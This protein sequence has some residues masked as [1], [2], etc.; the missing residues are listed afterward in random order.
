MPSGLQP[1]FPQSSSARLLMDR[2]AGLSSALH[3]L[4]SSSASYRSALEGLSTANDKGIET[5]PATSTASD[6]TQNGAWGSYKFDSLA[7]LQTAIDHAQRASTKGQ[8]KFGS[9]FKNQS[10]KDA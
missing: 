6:A 5:T 3:Q 8:S 9:V 4:A 2:T 7:A 10:L 1:S